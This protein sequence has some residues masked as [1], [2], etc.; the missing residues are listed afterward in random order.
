MPMQDRAQATVEAL[1]EATA[2]VLVEVGYARLSTNRVAKRAGVSIGSLYQYFADKDALVDALARRVSERQSAVIV[3]HILS[4]AGQ[5]LPETIRSLIYGVIAA[6]R[7]EPV[8]SQALVTQVPR[9]GRVDVERTMLRRLSEV[10]SGALQRRRSE[11]RVQNAE[12]AAFTLVHATFAVIRG[13]LEDRPELLA[14]DALADELVDLCV[15]YLLRPG[16]SAED[17]FGAASAP[18]PGESPRPRGV[19]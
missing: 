16:A 13:A 4:S 7:V 15:H 17:A 18:P 12:L 3:D 1:L 10:V 11:V 6:K 19:A 9:D 2:R 8:L 5:P 14:D